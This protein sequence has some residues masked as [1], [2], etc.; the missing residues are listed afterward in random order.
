MLFIAIYLLFLRVLKRC[1]VY[2]LNLYLS[3]S[4]LGLWIWAS[5]SLY[6]A[7]KKFEVM[8]LICSRSLPLLRT[9]LAVVVAS[10][11]PLGLAVGTPRSVVVFWV[12]LGD[13]VW[14]FRQ[15]AAARC[16]SSCGWLWYVANPPAIGYLSGRG[17]S[18]V[19]GGVI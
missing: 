14:S 1:I 19:N 2:A 10:A 6:N 13:L 5:L 16:G 17:I 4:G 12:S 7:S 9:A 18:S 8:D 3:C 15:F 11:F